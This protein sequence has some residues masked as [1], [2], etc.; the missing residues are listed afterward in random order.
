M[1]IKMWCL[2]NKKKTGIIKI[3]VGRDIWVA[4]FNKKSP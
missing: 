1:K 3:G 4:G 2:I